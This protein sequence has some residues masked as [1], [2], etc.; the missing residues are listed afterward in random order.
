MNQCMGYIRYEQANLQSV[1]EAGKCLRPTVAFCGMWTAKVSRLEIICRYA[2]RL[3]C[4]LQDQWMSHW[5]CKSEHLQCMKWQSMG[6]LPTGLTR[7]AR[8][9]LQGQTAQ[10]TWR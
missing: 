3:C 4:H 5:R 10:S 2:T 6:Q 7:I 1:V 9:R 8:S